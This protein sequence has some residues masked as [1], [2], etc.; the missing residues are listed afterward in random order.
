MHKAMSGS[1]LHGSGNGKSR[2]RY[3]LVWGEEWR[4]HTHT[5][6]SRVD[7]SQCVRACRCQLTQHGKRGR[8]VYA[9]VGDALAID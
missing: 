8:E 3:Q 9:S 6:L 5:L 7:C 1:S 4:L 2:A